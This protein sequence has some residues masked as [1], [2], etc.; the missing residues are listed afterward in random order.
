MKKL[1]SI[2]LISFVF[3]GVTNFSSAQEETSENINLYF[4]Y[5]STCPVCKKADSFLNKMKEKYPSLKVNNYE[6]FGNKENAKLFLEL[7]ESCGEEKIVRVPV[8]FIGNEVISGYLNEDITGKIIEKAIN[9]CLEG[10]CPNPLDK[11]KKCDLCKCL[12]DEELC[13]CNESCACK[14]NTEQNQ[15]IEFPLIGE[16]NISK[17]SLP[18]LTLVIAALDGF[19][20]CAMWL[21]LFLIA[22]LINVRSRKKIWIVGGTFIA[23][24]GVVYFLLLAAWLN[25][26]LAISYV[27]LT[28]II[29]GSVALIAGIWQ[30]KNFI[31]FKP[32]VCKVAPIGGKWHEKLLNK[33]QQVVQSKTLFV[34]I[35][36][37]IVLALGVNFL[38]FF[39]SAGLPA[40]YTKILSLSNLSS[41][42]YY[43]YLLFYTIV[44]MVDDFIVF[45]IAMVTLRKIGFTEK[46]TKWSTLIGGILILI[47]GL[48]L[49]FKPDLLM[50][51]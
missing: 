27:T 28:R 11:I 29:I 31:E 48:I 39:C 4:F 44:F 33:A 19:N 43:L 45:A 42:E 20:P 35:F 47:L 14:K 18:L 21:L 49:I 12:D 3:L 38:E 22:L 24:S 8:I 17:M 50:F 6:V 32:G 30:I 40:I 15:I 1:I 2:I 9:K 13:E 16:V 5:G 23:V 10:E 25:L 7:L 34:T 46:Y 51:G 26:F 36:G 37:V 41:I